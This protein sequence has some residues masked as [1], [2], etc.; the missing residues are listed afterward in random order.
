V[1]AGS[2]AD[3]QARYPTAPGPVVGPFS[4]NLSNAG[5]E[6]ILK[7]TQGTI[8]SFYYDD[9]SPWPAAADGTG[10]SLVLLEPDTNPDHGQGAQWAASAAAGGTPGANEWGTG[11]FTGPD[12]AADGDGDGLS[13]FL[14]HALGTSDSSSASGA[15]NLSAQIQS[16]SPG[17]ATAEY[18]TL[19]ITVPADS[20]VAHTVE[21]SASL[22]AWQS[23]PSHVVLASETP[24]P[25]NTTTQTWRSTRPFSSAAPEYIRLRV[26]VP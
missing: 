26:W 14:E 20:P 18:L 24:G 25:N 13:A 12:P 2:P 23:G 21:T 19:V 9:A 5:E 16:F 4:G 15:G 11:G 17:G 7:G 1:V 6:I 3:F 22:D 8:R 10:P